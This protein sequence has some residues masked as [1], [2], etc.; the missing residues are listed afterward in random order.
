MINKFFNKDDKP[1]FVGILIMN[2]FL[3]VSAQIFI[4]DP[5]SCLKKT[6]YVEKKNEKHK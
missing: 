2:L 6:K 4:I 3:I 1:F 5:P